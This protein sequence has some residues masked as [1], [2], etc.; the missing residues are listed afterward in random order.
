MPN[1]NN[2]TQIKH[3]LSHTN[4]TPTISS[5][6][7]C[8]LFLRCLPLHLPPLPSPRGWPPQSQRLMRLR[9]VRSHGSWRLHFNHLCCSHSQAQTWRHQLSV[10]EVSMSPHPSPAT[11]WCDPFM[12]LLQ[13]GA[14]V[15][16]FCSQPQAQQLG[17]KASP[18][19]V[20]WSQMLLNSSYGSSNG[21]PQF[22]GGSS[23]KSCSWKL[24]LESTTWA[25][26]WVW[27]HLTG[28]WNAF[29]FK[30]GGWILAFVIWSQ[31]IPSLSPHRTHSF[32]WDNNN[33]ILLV[34][35]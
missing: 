18:R 32:Y 3:L 16:Q 26:Q 21:V 23:C 20:A 9:S 34:L 29:L 14:G 11:S 4:E 30:T 31:V 22:W 12:E 5:F 24:S 13:T 8:L 25:I 33:F 10:G 35:D 7:I 28:L 27:G 15:A 17:D 2:Q 6:Q 19:G 1:A